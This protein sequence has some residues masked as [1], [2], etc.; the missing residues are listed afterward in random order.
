MELQFQGLRF[1]SLGAGYFR[2]GA[3]G[4][5][6]AFDLGILH[7]QVSSKISGEDPA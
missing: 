5:L 4:S 7:V 3:L 1:T 6:D 2:F